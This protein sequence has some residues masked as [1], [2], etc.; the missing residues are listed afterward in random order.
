MPSIL[1]GVKNALRSGEEADSIN[2]LPESVLSRILNKQQGKIEDATAVVLEIMHFGERENTRLEA[3]RE[4]LNLHGVR[5]DDS[6]HGGNINII[7][8][9]YDGGNEKERLDSVFNPK[10]IVDIESEVV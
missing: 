3:A 7:V 10:R 9:N 8:Q 1:Q 4:V 6:V 5:K 2:G